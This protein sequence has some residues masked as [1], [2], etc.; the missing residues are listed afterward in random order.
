MRKMV[1]FGILGYGWVA[2]DYML[3]AIDTEPRT[4]LVAVCSLYISEM[5]DLPE[6]LA[7]YTD[8]D[9]FLAHKNMDAVYIATPNHL[10]KTH[11]IA[12]LNA[13]QHV[14]C[15]KP[16]ATNAEDAR[17]M[18]AF[19]KAQYKV[20]ATAFDQ[21]FHP[22][23]LLMRALIHGHSL[24]KIAQ[25]RLDYA[26]WLP[27]EWSV[28]NWRVDKARAGGGAIIDLAPHGL[29]LLETLLG[30]E[31]IQIE[32]FMQSHVQDY[33]VDDGGVLLLRFASGVLGTMHVGYNR[34]DHLPR[35]RLEIMGDQ[36]MLSAVD[37]MGQE[38]G[39]TLTFTDAKEGKTCPVDFDADGSPFR[40]QLVNFIE[41]IR[42][43]KK[44]LRSPEDD[45]RL[46]ILLDNAL[47]K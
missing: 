34:P 8:L 17:A 41:L 47:K 11:T 44:P 37:T 3:K 2:R 35:R 31:I 26:C 32:L 46:Y 39:G 16:L 29:D 1:N 27:R 22:A 4:S 21:R 5:T 20:Y 19:A 9:E 33:E 10:H 36:G 18:I 14:L 42:D 30:D 38:P 25:V 12:C 13:G 45:L 23:H 6:T 7:K 28:D 40:L 24:G 43:H 15:E